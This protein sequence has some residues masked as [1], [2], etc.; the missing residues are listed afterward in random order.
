MPQL[1]INWNERTDSFGD[2]TNDIDGNLYYTREFRVHS[3]DRVSIGADPSQVTD[4][5][6]LLTL[7]ARGS[8]A[9]VQGNSP[10]WLYRYRLQSNDVVTDVFADYTNNPDIL[11]GIRAG[12]QPLVRAL[13]SMS[14]TVFS[15]RIPIG[16]RFSS[17]PITPGPLAVSTWVESDYAAQRRR[18]LLSYEFKVD[19]DNLGPARAAANAQAGML[20]LLSTSTL[21]HFLSSEDEPISAT[22][23]RMRYLWEIDYGITDLVVPPDLLPDFALPPAVEWGTAYFGVFNT[24]AVICPPYYRLR[25]MPA[26]VS[27]VPDHSQRPSFIVLPDPFRWDGTGLGWQGLYG[28]L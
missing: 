15:D 1:F 17:P 12:G 25:Y 22:H 18:A 27:G 16:V 5:D 2:F 13:D 23:S 24:G 21:A 11:A 19:I 7:P 20:H 3:P 8:Q 9:V 26:M 14:Q 10:V 6:T 28:I 4:P